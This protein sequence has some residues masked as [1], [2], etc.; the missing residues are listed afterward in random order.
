MSSWF[1]FDLVATMRNKGL[2]PMLTKLERCC[3]SQAVFLK[4]SCDNMKVVAILLIS[5]VLI[6]AGI[7][8]FL[9]PIVL[10]MSNVFP[11]ESVIPLHVAELCF[12]V[13]GGAAVLAGLGLTLWPMILAIV[14]NSKTKAAA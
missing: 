12:F 3:D 13:T 11:E 14:R 5:C 9:A 6:S 10:P 7:V 2:S 4:L 8:T 1:C